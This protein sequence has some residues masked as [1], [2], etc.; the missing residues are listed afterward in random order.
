MSLR[1]LS[2]LVGV[3]AVAC[4]NELAAPE[5]DAA[6]ETGDISETVGCGLLTGEVVGTDGVP[7]ADVIVSV[8]RGE[9]AG[10][11]VPQS[12]YGSSAASGKF[13]TGFVL[14]GVGEPRP[15]TGTDSLRL[16]VVAFLDVG[17][18]LVLGD[19]VEVLA[20]AAA[21]GS[22]PPR[23]AVEIELPVQTRPR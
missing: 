5:L 15:F 14:H 8:W 17:N 22:M 16:V 1:S 7:L 9:Q 18:G 21:V 4:A 12:P 2:I 11:H 20:A 19:S 13:A 6:C 23:T 3:A 10:I